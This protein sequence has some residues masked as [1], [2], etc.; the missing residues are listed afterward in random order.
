MLEALN[1]RRVA[2]GR[3]LL[4]DVSLTIPAGTRMTVAG[5]TGSGK[6]LLLRALARLDPIAAGEI[7]WRGSKVAGNTIPEFRSRVIYLHQRP[8]M[9]EGTVENNL[10]LPFS[11]DCRQSAQYS[12]DTILDLLQNVDLDETFCRR[13]TRD[14]SGGELQIVAVIRAIQLNPDVL[15]LDE[16]TA[17]L[18]EES[19]AAVESLLLRWQAGGDADRSFV[20]VS[21]NPGQVKRVTG[22]L[23]R[24]AGGR[25]HERSASHT[26]PSA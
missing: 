12:R 21:H 7:R 15:L 17:A 4:D 1:I 18:D 25:I 26:E 9:M 10:R 5:P 13:R 16:P 2:D 20:W 11:L 14:L 3:R 19:A 8:A 22:R 24:M 23:V 6:T